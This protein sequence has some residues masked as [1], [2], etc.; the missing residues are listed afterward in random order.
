MVEDTTPGKLCRDCGAAKSLEAFNKHPK[1][2]DGRQPHC[3][4]C[5]RAYGAR[6]YRANKARYEEQAKR[7]RAENPERAR[8]TR[9]RN[10][11]EN[12]PTAAQRREGWLRWRYGI[13][14]ADYEALFQTQGGICAICQ[15]S[16]AQALRVDHD[17]DTGQVRGL[18]CHNCNAMLGLVREDADVLSSAIR[19]LGSATKATESGS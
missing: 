16:S 7:W 6:H 13:S 18:L 5:Q 3:R 11:L 1:T 14:T 2:R 10:Y 8:A 15:L 17:H 19:Y 4:D 9:R 12:P